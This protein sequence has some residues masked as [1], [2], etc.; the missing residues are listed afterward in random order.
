MPFPETK[1]MGS[2]RAILPFILGHI[3]GLTF[4]TAMDAFSGSACVAY[5]IKAL[6]KRVISNDFHRFAFHIARA[7]I[8]N[9]STT[10]SEK[11]LARLTRRNAQAATFVRDTYAGLY[12]GEA[13]C[14]FIDETYANVQELR[15]PLKRSLALASL[16]RACMKKRPWGIFTFVGNTGMDGRRDLKLSLREHFLEAAKLFNQAV[17]SNGEANRALCQDVFDTSPRGID[18]VYID[19]PYVSEHSDCDYTRR[20]H[21]V[22]GL[23]SYWHG[24]ELQPYTV[25][26]KI[27]SYETAF[28]TRRSV[29]E[30][31]RRLFSHFQESILVVS[32]G[33]NG[34]PD[35]TH[36]VRLLREFKRHVRVEETNHRYCHGNHSH[37]VGRNHN[38]VR[39]YLFIAS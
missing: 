25:T 12:F 22:E 33:S 28:S 5:A 17:F 6:G 8:Q 38:S 23:C 31:F 21:F 24:V 3:K 36:M 39:E 26:K 16:C 32:Y 4:R 37:R 1:Y 20:Y 29:L 30:A 19:P 34:I 7:T 15:S 14:R 35:R 9:N 11:D 27:R 10:L 2:K 13:D 18:L